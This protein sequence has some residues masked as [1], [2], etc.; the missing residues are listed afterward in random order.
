MG[1]CAKLLSEAGG[2]PGSVGVFVFDGCWCPMPIVVPSDWSVVV[3]GFWN[4]AIL[5]PAGIVRRLYGLPEDTPVEVEVALDAIAPH[6]V[7]HDHVTVMAGSDRLIVSPDI[8]NYATLDTALRVART[9]LRSLPE[10][11]VLAAGF[12]LKY[13]SERHIESLAAVTAHNWDER[14]SDEGY[15][16]DS[17]LINR[18]LNWR[19]GQ[20]RVSV[21]QEPDLSFSIALNFDLRSNS[22]DRLH[23]W[24]AVPIRDVQEQTERILY[25]CLDLMPEEIANVDAA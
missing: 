22:A 4:R 12:N 14:L 5:T 19:D 3:V 21:A 6:R 25:R 24:L 20:I 16:I 13:K 17:R 1:L 9:A 8:C 2:A 23:D 11:P 18:A 15:T 7:K 10:T